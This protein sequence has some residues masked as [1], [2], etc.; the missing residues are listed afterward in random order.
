MEKYLTDDE[1]ACHSFEDAQ[2]IAEVLLKNDYVV[3]ISREEK[4]YIVNYIWTQN[5]A[6]R[7]EVCFLSRD[8]LTEAL[9]DDDCGKDS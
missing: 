3:M 1:I 4:L 8:A 7:N 2:K 9:Y 6:N 5:Y